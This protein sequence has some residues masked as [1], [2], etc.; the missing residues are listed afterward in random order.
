MTDGRRISYSGTEI[1]FKINEFFCNFAVIINDNN[2]IKPMKYT[3]LT[4]FLVILVAT[5]NAQEKIDTCSWNSLC[6]AAQNC[7][8]KSDYFTATKYLEK[9]AKIHES[10]TLKRKLAVCYYNRGYYRQCTKLCLSVL[11]PDTLERDL[12]LL[13]KSLAK[14]ADDPDTLI[15][16][17]RILFDRNPLNQ[18]NTLALAQSLMEYESIDAASYCLQKYYEIDSTNLSVNALR[19]KIFFMQEKYE[20]AIEEFEK[21]IAAGSNLPANYYYLGVAARKTYNY[22]KALEN[23]EIANQLTMECN[24]PVLTQLGLAQLAVDSVSHRGVENLNNAVEFMQPNEKTLRTIY[25]HLAAYYEH[26]NWRKS[27]DYYL[28]TKDLGGLDA[29]ISYRISI[30]YQNLKNQ[31]KEIE[32]LSKFL[33]LSDDSIACDYARQRIQHLKNERFMNGNN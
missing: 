15:F 4:A 19:A 10:D 1:F 20:T 29:S 27:L 26:R 8:E 7:I 13:T 14:S 9:A 31:P 25:Y 6:D 2:C 11:T 24:P 33:D 16:F 3:I 17:Q 32:Y 21:I 5:S 18:N 28:K 22:P 12:M 23:L 30:C